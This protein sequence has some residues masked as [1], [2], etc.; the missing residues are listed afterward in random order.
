V[1]LRQLDAAYLTYRQGLPLAADHGLDASAAL[2]TE[3]AKATS[4]SAAWR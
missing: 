1:V 2:E 3:L 4:S